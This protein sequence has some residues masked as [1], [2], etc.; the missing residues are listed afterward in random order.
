MSETAWLLPLRVNKPWGAPVL[1]QG[2]GCFCP[3]LDINMSCRVRYFSR[4]GLYVTLGRTISGSAFHELR[5]LWLKKVVPKWHPGK[6]SQR[7]KPGSLILSH[8]QMFRL[9]ASRPSTVIDW[10]QALCKY[11]DPVRQ[12]RQSTNLFHQW[13]SFLPHN[14]FPGLLLTSQEPRAI[15]TSRRHLQHMVS[16]LGLMMKVNCCES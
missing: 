15:T 6:W 9:E 11:L 13:A 5:W 12:D 8:T 4:T 14:L 7:L 10:R 16:W 2:A 3:G 1:P